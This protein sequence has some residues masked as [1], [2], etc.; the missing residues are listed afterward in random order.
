MSANAAPRETQVAL[1]ATCFVALGPLTMSMY[2]PA[3]PALASKLETSASLVQLTLTVYLVAFA[4][5]QL[6]YGPVSDRFGR[7]PVLIVGLTVYVAASAMAGAVTGIWG[8]MIARFVQALG[9]CA[10]PA[11]ARAI[12]RDQF[13]EAASARVYALIGLAIAVVPAVGPLLGGYMQG[14]TGWRS[15]FLAQAAFGLTLLIATVWLVRETNAGDAK[16]PIAPRAVAKGYA[17]LLADRRFLGPTAL[18]A[19]AIGGLLT[20]VAAAPFVLIDLV[21]LSPVAY[22]WVAL[23]IS[24]SYFGG[25]I[26]TNRIVGRT[27]PDRLLC[28]GALAILAGGIGLT[29]ALAVGW[30]GVVPVV[31]PMCLWMVGMGLVLPNGLAKAMAPFPDRA[32]AASALVGFLQIGTG[33]AGTLLVA[34]LEDGT[35]LALA[36]A[37]T[38][39]GIV[40]V[41]A[42][43]LL[44]APARDPLDLDVEEDDRPHGR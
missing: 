17:E 28:A 15:I 39:V 6:V 41:A 32:G 26:L 37:P 34:A 4:S 21:G 11:M 9:A 42:F 29:A 35:P 18:L 24:G 22:G 36:V 12:V 31:L 5:A 8:L 25:S 44:T 14:W 38:T 33:A 27:G 13:A 43:A 3:M 10:G 23:S 19:C 20:F 1:M 16:R 40:G 30:V 7:R 2:T